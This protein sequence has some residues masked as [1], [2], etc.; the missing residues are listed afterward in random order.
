MGR[1][2]RTGSLYHCFFFSS[3]VKNKKGAY[4]NERKKTNLFSSYCRHGFFPRY[5]LC[6]CRRSLRWWFMGCQYSIFCK[7]FSGSCK[8]GFTTTNS[9]S[10]P[11]TGFGST[12]YVGTEYVKWDGK[13]EYDMYMY[14]YAKDENGKPMSSTQRKVYTGWEI[15]YCSTHFSIT[16][17]DKGNKLYL[18]IENS[19]YTT[20]EINHLTDTTIQKMP[21]KGK[22]WLG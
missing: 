3:S 17:T 2:T 19:G 22:F 16:P 6:F 21:C 11:S 12:M 20:N 9:I 15:G 10:K 4:E 14:V 13:A 5:I 18:R 8:Y 7:V 1:F